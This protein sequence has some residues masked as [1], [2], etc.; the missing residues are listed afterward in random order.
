MN[1]IEYFA[2]GSNLNTDQLKER[3]VSIKS[4]QKVKLPEWNLAFTIYSDSWGG[5]VGDILPS[6]DEI[7]EGVVYRIDRES[8]R[9][10]DHYEGRNLKDDM[11]VGMYRK[12]YIP[13]KM[14]DGWRTVL[15]YVVNRSIE[16]KL[17]V[18]LKPS[19]EYMDTIISGA[20]EHELSD[21][22]I[23]KLKNIEC[24]E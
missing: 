3:G 6:K 8:V 11:E 4:S 16:H 17:K 2:Y 13:V 21:H 7:V 12:Q 18:N 10:L 9:Q 24:K 5:G 19:E 15:T 20:R 22:Y 23:E 1:R 14:E